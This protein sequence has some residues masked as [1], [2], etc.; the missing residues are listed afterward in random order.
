MQMGRILARV[1][2]LNALTFVVGLAGIARAADAPG[3]IAFR[4]HCRAPDAKLSVDLA[5][6]APHFDSDRDWPFG[7]SQLETRVDDLLFDIACACDENDKQGIEWYVVD[8]IVAKPEGHG[9]RFERPRRKVPVERLAGTR[10]IR[11]VFDPGYRQRK[12]FLAKGGD[13]RDWLTQSLGG[14]YDP[15]L[16]KEEVQNLMS[17]IGMPPTVRFD[18]GVLTL[19]LSPASTTVGSLDTFFVRLFDLALQGKPTAPGGAEPA[20]IR[21]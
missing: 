3:L 8:K 17:T 6:F 2:A 5:A 19:G 13:A 1:A 21:K 18:A 11:V 14:L 7:A 9:T 15:K 20:K 10:E 4:T 16:V 12:A